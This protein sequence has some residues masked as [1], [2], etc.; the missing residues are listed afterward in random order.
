MALG[1]RSIVPVL[2]VVLFVATGCA[3]QKTR[4]APRVDLTEF[5]SVGIVGFGADDDD[6]L[7]ELATRQFLQMLQNAQ[8]DARIV[9]LGSERRV[10]SEVRRRELD[11]EA[12]R[13]LGER[14]GVE[15]VFAGG[16]ELSRMKPRVEFGESFSSVNAS[17]HVNG[18]L[19][20][21]LFETRSGAT[22]WTRNATASADVA[23]IGV[24][25][26]GTPTFGAQ[27]PSEVQA[28]LVRQLVADLRHDFYPT[29]RR[30]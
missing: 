7:A 15:A 26:G 27:D 29:W 4:V 17:A 18:E 22:V 6:E 12:A 23:S 9:E 10:L 5:R 16:L 20:A 2:L 3:S 21:R 1:V 13:A 24:P 30:P 8:P 19:G 25:E 28:G 11:F 14:Y